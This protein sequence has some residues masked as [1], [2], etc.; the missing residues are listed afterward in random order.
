MEYWTCALSSP[1][2]ASALEEITLCHG[3]NDTQRA[4][5][6]LGKLENS[7]HTSGFSISLIND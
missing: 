6:S 2:P 7:S 5:L 4:L 1:L 3:L